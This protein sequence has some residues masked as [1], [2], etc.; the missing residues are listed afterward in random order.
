[1]WSDIRLQ[2]KDRLIISNLRRFRI[3]TIWAAPFENV[4]RHTRT[5]KAQ[6]SLRIRAVLLG[7]VLS[8]KRTIWH[9]RMSHWRA[10]ARMRLR[11]CAVWIRIF[12]FLR[13]FE[14]ICL[15]AV[16]HILSCFQLTIK[17]EIRQWQLRGFYSTESVKIIR[18]S[19]NVK[20]YM[21]RGIHTLCKTLFFI[22]L[23]LT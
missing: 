20:Q 14:D 23:K 8:A 18:W 19:V 11:A 16:V 22:L 10:N 15:L 17:S 7:P 1:M 3:M 5:A 2:R 6:I 4:F 9:N 21:S 13:M 12:E